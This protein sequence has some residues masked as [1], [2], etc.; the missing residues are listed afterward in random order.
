MES[1]LR[2]TWR[3]IEYL[4]IDGG[5][6]DGT[7]DVIREY[8]AKFDGRMRWVSERDRGMYD[9]INKGIRMAAGEVV[10][11]LNADDV[12]ASDEM[13]EHVAKIFV[14]NPSCEAIYGDI[15]F[16][17]DCREVTLEKL[18]A[19]KT[20]RYYS[21]KYFRPWLARFGYLPAH[22]SYYCIREVFDKLGGYQTDYRIAADHELMIRS[23]VKER[24]VSRYVPEVFV[25]MRM[26][27]MSTRSVESTL[28]LNRENIRACQANGIYTNR[29]LQLGKYLF[30]VP[31][32]V[33][34]DGY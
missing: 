19:E 2:Q 3:E 15:R 13:I 28:V 7:V 4:V 33:F 9:A 6:T 32:L 22:P 25:V 17:A 14:E 31:G 34:R 16:V 26:G 30:K 1:V 29:L 20:V 12:L 27:G 24:L 5:S 10:G 11:I 21:S 23:L 18:R 8:E